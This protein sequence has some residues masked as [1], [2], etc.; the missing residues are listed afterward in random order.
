[1]HL[2]LFLVIVYARTLT[3]RCN[4]PVINSTAVSISLRSVA[5]TRALPIQGGA[6]RPKDQGVVALGGGVLCQFHGH[7]QAAILVPWSGVQQAIA[8]LQRITASSSPRPRS[9]I[10]ANRPLRST[11]AKRGC[12]ALQPLLL[13][14]AGELNLPARRTLN[15][16]LQRLRHVQPRIL[17]STFRPSQHSFPAVFSTPPS[18]ALSQ[19]SWAPITFLTL[20]TCTISVRD[21]IDVPT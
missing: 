13:R 1:M 15:F 14:A 18:V 3:E 17:S 11:P 6:V 2:A 20:C 16:S 4:W 21:D 9:L 7:P 5:R 12:P 8:P 10:C 19:S